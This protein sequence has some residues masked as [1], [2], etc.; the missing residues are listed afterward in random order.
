MRA[1]APFQ[2]LPE[3]RY[4][5]AFLAALYKPRCKCRQLF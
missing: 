4:F 5:Y 3:R 2:D 1:K